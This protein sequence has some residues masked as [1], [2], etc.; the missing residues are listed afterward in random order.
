MERNRRNKSMKD[1]RVFRRGFKYHVQQLIGGKWIDQ[2]IAGRTILDYFENAG[3]A[4]T[5]AKHRQA[6]L[7][8]ERAKPQDDD[9]EII[10][11]ED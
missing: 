7:D 5:Y 3:Q 4:L 11:I 8:R 9:G 6:H 1:F 2:E 10:V